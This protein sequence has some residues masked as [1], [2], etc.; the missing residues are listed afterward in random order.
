MTTVLKIRGLWGCPQPKQT[1]KET[2]KK[3]TKTYQD[4]PFDD[5]GV[6]DAKKDDGKTNVPNWRQ[7]MHRGNE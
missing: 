7:D 3:Q 4:F 5:G 1:N 2:D 6:G